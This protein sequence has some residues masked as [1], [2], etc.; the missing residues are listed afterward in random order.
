MPAPIHHPRVTRDGRPNPLHVSQNATCNQ[1]VA[2][3]TFGDP[4]PVTFLNLRDSVQASILRQFGEIMT[5]YGGDGAWQDEDEHSGAFLFALPTNRMHKL[6]SDL[7]AAGRYHSQDAIGLIDP[8]N[9][10][11]LLYPDAPD[12]SAPESYRG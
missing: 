9:D 6:R 5:E 12:M 8:G 10:Q 3:V 11:T 7:R 4:N 2:V 1:T